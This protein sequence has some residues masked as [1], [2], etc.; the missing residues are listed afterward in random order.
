MQKNLEYI[1]ML[2]NVI[3]N[4]SDE[5]SV[6][7]RIQMKDEIMSIT[8]SF[9]QSYLERD[10]EILD[11]LLRDH[12]KIR[13][14]V[15]KFLRQEENDHINNSL[16][17]YVQTFNIFNKLA[18]AQIDEMSFENEMEMIE[19]NYKHTLQILKYLY[20][21]DHVSHKELLEIYNGLDYVLDETMDILEKVGCIQQIKMD[22]GSF[23][24]LTHRGKKYIKKYYKYICVKLDRNL[25]IGNYSN[26]KNSYVRK[27][28]ARN[29]DFV[30][31]MKSIK[32]GIS[33]YEDVAEK[34]KFV[35]E[36][37]QEM[38]V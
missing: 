33:Y 23:Y 8:N 14:T 15:T 22:N 1:T 16:A 32:Q 2:D 35:D 37:K 31:P 25:M 34:Q 29:Y 3:K 12:R 20:T 9:M 11:D 30:N 26:S 38:L 27:V 4:S 10:Y 36:E 19:D 28:E 7:D 17:Q 21:H 24:N 13:N 5:I 6:E 18:Q